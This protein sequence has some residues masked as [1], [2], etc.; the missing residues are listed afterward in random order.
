MGRFKVDDNNRLLLLKIRGCALLLTKLHHLLSAEVKRM[1]SL[2]FQ[3]SWACFIAVLYWQNSLAESLRCVVHDES[4]LYSALDNISCA[5][6]SIVTMINVTENVLVTRPLTLFGDAID[7][8]LVQINP[9]KNNL[10]I[11]D[12]IGGVHVF[13]LRISAIHAQAAVVVANASNVL[14]D[15][16]E[17]EGSSSIFAVFIAGRDIPAGIPT[18]ENYESRIEMDTNNTFCNSLVHS[19]WEGDSLSFSLQYRGH[20]RNNTVVDGGKIAFYMNAECSCVNN[21]VLDSISQ[22]I[23]LSS[24]SADNVLVNNTILNAK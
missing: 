4:T 9:N 19:S 22:G 5:E 14:I 17:V 2:H 11:R 18:L 16:V 15:S 7:A 20:L 3:F 6:I 21:T 8:A 24:P 13:N 10:Y 12:V 1:G 23:F